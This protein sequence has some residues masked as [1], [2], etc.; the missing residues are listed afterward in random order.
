MSAPRTEQQEAFARA[1]AADR[2]AIV[3]TS[4]E[5]GGPLVV[6]ASRWCAAPGCMASPAEFAPQLVIAIQ[7]GRIPVPFEV[8]GRCAVHG[9][10]PRALPEPAL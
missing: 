3:F 4:T 2:E 8:P 9:A 1:L 5:R 6:W 7:R 10:E